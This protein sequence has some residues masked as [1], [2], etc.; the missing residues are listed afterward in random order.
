MSPEPESNSSTKATEPDTVAASIV[1]KDSS[2]DSTSTDTADSGEA[3]LPSPFTAHTTAVAIPTGTVSK[4]S[5]K[6]ATPATLP[7]ITTNDTDARRLN[8]DNFTLRFDNIDDALVDGLIS[9]EPMTIDNDDVTTV[10]NATN[11]KAWVTK[12]IS[13]FGEDYLL[14]P[15]DTSKDSP[16]QLEWFAR[17]QKQAHATVVGIISAKT[18][19]H[20]E[21]SCW[22]LFDALVKAHELGIIN[23]GNS[24]TP[25]ELI[26]SKRLDFIVSIIEK[27]ALIRLDV[28]RAW[29]VD[30]IAANP[31][32]FIKRKLVNCWN[33]RHRAEK[34]KAAKEEKEVEKVAGKDQS[35][36]DGEAVPKAAGK[37][38][39]ARTAGELAEQSVVQ[40]PVRGKKARK[41]DVTSGKATNNDD[42]I[43]D[44]TN[45]TTKSKSGTTKRSCSTATTP[46]S[47]G[48]KS[49]PSKRP[50]DLE[51]PSDE[52]VKSHGGE[53]NDAGDEG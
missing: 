19:V 13:A 45:N 53:G 16:A 8:I 35:A 3:V 4:K 37:K 20:L 12:L 52:G 14:T 39:A 48:K 7:N 17:W 50:A 23:P 34:A 21:K 6:P 49:T 31:E 25:S 47:D 33:N 5:L 18:P 11:S 10:K 29:H 22:H 30:E 51:T 24:L 26:C 38:R 28:L 9:R 1:Q 44:T 27:Y 2:P 43:K 32:A 40:T 36:A 42:T 41:S 15:E 46:G